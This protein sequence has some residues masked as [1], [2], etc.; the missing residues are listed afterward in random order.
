[1]N[2]LEQNPVAPPSGDV[3]QVVEH[4]FRHE[5]GKLVA[6][7]TGIFGIENLSLSEDVV[8]EALVR[9][10]KTWPYYGLPANPSAWLMRTAKNL[11]LD[12]LRREKV[13]R[14]K[15]PQITALME[16]VSS[17]EA[18]DRSWEAGL[19]DDTLRMMFACCHPLIA[20][21]AQVA[22]ALKTL[23]G[24][25]TVEIAKAFL[26]TEA[27]IAKRLTRAK[28]KLREAE[29]SFELPSAEE[30][31]RRLDSVSHTVYLLFNE[32]Y[33]AS[34]GERLLKEELCREAI[35][36]A[37]FL[38]EHPVGNRPQTHALLA[39][40][41]LNA[42]RLPARVD[43][44]GKIVALKEQ[45]R[46]NWDQALIA[47]G[48]F[49]LA[50]SG[51]GDELTKYHL[52]AGIAA[53]HCAAQDFAS[54]D[55]PQ[56]LALYDRMVALDGSAVVALNR[57]VAVAHVSGPDAGIAAVHAI[58]GREQLDAYYLFYAVLA[59]FQERRANFSAAADLFRQ[60]VELTDLISE[61]NFLLKRLAACE[62]QM[63]G[64]TGRAAG[65]FLEP[66]RSFGA[67]VAERNPQTTHG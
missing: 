60:A 57:A 29:V 34:T 50:Q 47:R 51:A 48:L 64:R 28:Q 46:A 52:E 24:F 7:L 62:G 31:S 25:G 4:L 67:G 61:R 12:V 2:Q 17:E 35:R 44:A 37:G 42:A 9:A 6:T 10:L 8:Q 41:L 27:T 3:S 5:A 38:V 63:N 19:P 23:C 45:D 39:L 13:F 30:L 16:D 14:A 49:H 26:T 55:W 36:L 43:A 53:C 66:F 54:T 18:D 40:M 59:D 58:A 65:E 32:G 20:P 1:V 33:K 11:A 22:L 15:Q 21:E 56:I